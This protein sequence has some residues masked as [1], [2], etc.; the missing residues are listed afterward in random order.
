MRAN[1]SQFAVRRQPFW[2]GAGL[3]LILLAGQGAGT[4]RGMI[5]YAT[6]DPTHNTSPPAGTLAGSGWNYQGQWSLFCGT[7]IA[8]HYFI[9]AKH[10]FGAVGGAFVYGGMTCTTTAAFEHPQADLRIWRVR[11]TLPSYAPLYTR[12]NEIG[13]AVV[14]MGRGCPR[15]GPV[16][17]AS[18][19]DHE[20]K[21]WYWGAS[22]NLMRWGQNRVSM[23]LVDPDS[24]AEVLK[25]D[26]DTNG[27]E[28]EATLSAGDSGG[29]V[30]MLDGATWKLAGINWAV[31]ALFNTNSQ[32]DG[33]YAAIIDKGGLYGQETNGWAFTVETPQMQPSAFYATRISSYVAWIQ[34]I[35]AQAIPPELWSAERLDGN[36][37]F[38]AGAVADAGAKTLQ[39]AI[40]S[41]P[42]FYRLQDTVSRRI[43]AITGGTNFLTIS[44]Q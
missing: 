23:T 10:V 38:E 15:G 17:T 40:P 8:P 29:G 31:E 32:G 27:G 9:T 14:I 25:M 33:F 42:R 19:Y 1:S 37:A 30:F 16:S 18:S 41:G 4:A 28:N 39:V 22:D 21:G 12:R 7:A 44:Y 2:R 11:E 43:T 13:R 36:Y 5:F 24:S 20:L 34:Q 3:L 35:L 6:G 26:F